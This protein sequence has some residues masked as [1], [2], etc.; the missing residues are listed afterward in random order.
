MNGHNASSRWW[1][2]PSQCVATAMHLERITWRLCH[3]IVNLCLYFIHITI[4]S[5]GIE[6]KK[7]TVYDWALKSDGCIVNLSIQRQ[8]YCKWCVLH[9]NRRH[10]NINEYLDERY[11]KIFEPFDD[12]WVYVGAILR[13]RCEQVGWRLTNPHGTHTHTERVI[14]RLW[15]GSWMSFKQPVNFYRG[16]MHIW[17]SSSPSGHNIMA[18]HSWFEQSR[19]R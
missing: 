14:S 4:Y 16:C 7:S 13:K 9:S 5:M 2:H 12:L 1:W 6:M 11:Q 17:L 10:K 8:H 15:L 19:W 18:A 3:F